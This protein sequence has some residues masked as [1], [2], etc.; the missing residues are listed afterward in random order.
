MKEINIVTEPLTNIDKKLQ[1]KF[2]EDIANQSSLLD[3][4]GKQLITLE[5]AIPGGYATA[6]KVIKGSGATF[7]GDIFLYTTFGLWFLSLILTFFA[8]F[9]KKYVVDTDNLN[10]IEEYFIKS[11][12]H[13]RFYLIISS[14][15][16]FIGIVLSL[17][18]IV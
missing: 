13:K 10:E 14:I 1:E 9:P 5:L 17:F 3:S 7:S 11:A 6:L 12:K 4:L 2:T 8:I 16:F 15:T 18:T